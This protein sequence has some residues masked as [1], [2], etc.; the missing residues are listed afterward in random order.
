MI[1]SWGLHRASASLNLDKITQSDPE[2]AQIQHFCLFELVWIQANFFWFWWCPEKIR[3]CKYFQAQIQNA[4]LILW[5]QDSGRESITMFIS[6][7]N[8]SC[9][10]QIQFDHP[11]M[12]YFILIRI[13]IMIPNHFLIK[14]GFKAQIKIFPILVW[15]QLHVIHVLR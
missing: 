2:Q 6:W 12:F 5:I 8:Q 13:M 3:G 10:A 1:R 14:Q 7:D 11:N 15:S 4:F 9:Q